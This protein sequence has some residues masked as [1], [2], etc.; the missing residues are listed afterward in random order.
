MKK[1]ILL[2]LLSGITL[3]VVH[4]ILIPFERIQS[5]LQSISVKAM[6]VEPPE[7]IGWVYSELY[8]FFFFI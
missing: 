6:S 8:Y 4:K 3:L 7:F 2:L 5:K 1:I